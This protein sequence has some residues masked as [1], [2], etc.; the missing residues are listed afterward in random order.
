MQSYEDLHEI[1]EARRSIRGYKKD[2][3]VPEE[4]RKWVEDD[5]NKQE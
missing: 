4:K 2:Q 1:G 5:L 3:D